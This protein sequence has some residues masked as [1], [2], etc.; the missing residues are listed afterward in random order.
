MRPC[1][2][3]AVVPLFAAGCSGADDAKDK[4]PAAIYEAV[5]LEE[6]KGAGKGEAF[7]VFVDGVDPAPDLLKRLKMRWPDLEPGSKAP[8]RGK[9]NRVS[10]H[11]LKW[12]TGAVAELAAGVSN[13]MDGR[14]S[15]YR[16]IRKGDAWHI[17]SAKVEFES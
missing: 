12:L 2:L 8:V 4:D 11:S 15:R 14:G 7:Y 3:L 16:V 17:E 9:A 6:L 10:F 13:G 1:F 5:L